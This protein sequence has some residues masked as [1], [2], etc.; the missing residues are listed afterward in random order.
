MLHLLLAVKPIDIMIIAILA[1]AVVG[2]IIVLVRRKKKGIMGCGCGCTT[3]P[4][5]GGCPS[6]TQKEESPISNDEENIDGKA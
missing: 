2:V 6:S 4:H 3:C 5:A 1:L